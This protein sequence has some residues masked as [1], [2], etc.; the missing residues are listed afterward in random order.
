ME[1]WCE[2]TR[3]MGGTISLGTFTGLKCRMRF[4][5]W[6]ILTTALGLAFWCAGGL[7]FAQDKGPQDNGATAAN[8]AVSESDD[9]GEA[10]PM[11][12]EFAKRLGFMILD[13]DGPLDRDQ[14]KRLE[15][16]LQD[17]L[18]IYPEFAVYTR[19]DFLLQ[20]GWER[21]HG[22]LDCQFPDDCAKTLRERLA[23][24]HEMSLTIAERADGRWNIRLRMIVGDEGRDF[25]EVS[26]DLETAPGL[27]KAMMPD[28]I[29]L[30]SSLRAGQGI[31]HVGSFP[32][33][34][35]VSLDGKP[36]GRTP[37]N[38]ALAVG[39]EVTVVTERDGH[40]ALSNKATVTAGEVARWHADLVTR[41]GGLLVDS[42]PIGAS[43]YVDEKPVGQTPVVLHNILAGAHK[44]TLRMPPFAN[45]I[46]DVT[47]PPDEMARVQ[48]GF[49][50][51]H[52]TLIVRPANPK[53]DSNVEIYLNEALV[54]KSMYTANLPPGRYAVAIV[55]KGFET[56]REIVD[57][58]SGKTH[59]VAP[60]LEKGF[61]LKPGQTAETV[62]DYRPGG[63]S[64]AFGALLLGFG[65][66]L[67]LEAQNHESIASDIPVSDS[68][69]DDHLKVA[70]D[71]RIAGGVLMG[72]GSAALVAGVVLLIIP[73]GKAIA[74]TPVVEPD[75]SGGGV[76]MTWQY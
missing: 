34:A 20:V 26:P 25:V 43:V 3:S 55:A 10:S 12:T 36:V 64:T 42:N 1:I 63:F 70:R 75:G 39:V 74:V 48:H 28:L 8:T 33:G 68:D 37:I 11:E 23:I 38:L 44:V 13:V 46:Y 21:Q 61:S 41:Q 60:T 16:T 72:V 73:P 52:G 76:S 59:T 49:A 71:S 4:G 35:M 54:A 17:A 32:L 30:P 2:L 58:I 57:L 22:L 5:T 51:T 56:Y 50:A 40:P 19:S 45:A 6:L 53:L 66:Y 62:P 69:H 9:D 29:G 27:I 65:V 24:T 67:E 47:V 18:Y 14:R 31:L 15:A 7:V